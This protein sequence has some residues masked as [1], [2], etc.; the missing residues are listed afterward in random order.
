[1]VSCD[2]KVKTSRQKASRN[3]EKAKYYSNKKQQQPKV[4]LR[5][6]ETP[7]KRNV[8]E[9]LSRKSDFYYYCIPWYSYCY[10]C[11]CS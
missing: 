1:M 7:E 11:C 6:T 10:F 3:K 8:Q 4:S 9:N 2:I 5:K